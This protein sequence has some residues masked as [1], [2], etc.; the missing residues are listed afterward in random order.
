MVEVLGRANGVTPQNGTND[1]FKCGAF[2]CGEV[3]LTCPWSFAEVSVAPCAPKFS[4]Q[5]STQD[6]VQ[7]G[8]NPPLF[9]RPFSRLLYLGVHLCHS[10]RL[11]HPEG[12][13][14]KTHKEPSALHIQHRAPA[15]PS[16]EPSEGA[17]STEQVSCI[18]GSGWTSH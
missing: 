9:E 2:A 7:N 6:V 10:L 11:I 14:T 8:A 3:D 1:G 17:E 15:L 13:R 16:L 12:W 18:T 4:L 5:Q